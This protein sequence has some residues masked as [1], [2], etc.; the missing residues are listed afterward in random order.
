MGGTQLHTVIQN[1]G[2]RKLCYVLS[3]LF[4]IPGLREILHIAKQQNIQVS[5]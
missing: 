5:N 4:E 1:T 2:L 3:T